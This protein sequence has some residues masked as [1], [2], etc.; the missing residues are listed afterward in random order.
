MTMTNRPPADPP[1][2]DLVVRRVYDAPR[3]LVWQAWTDPHH[4]AQWWGPRM[5]TNPLCEVDLRPGGTLLIHMRAPDGTV[6]PMRGV[7]EEVVPPE[8]LVFRDSALE[9][10]HGQPQL[11]SLTTVLFAERGRQTEVTVRAHV[12]TA[13]AAALGAL[14]G[15]EQG[16]NESLDKLGEYLPAMQA[17]PGI[18]ITRTFDAPRELVFQ[19]WTE[20]ARFAQWFGAPN[21]TIP[22]DT[23]SMDLRP[24]GAWR[25][26]MYAGPERHA[27]H[28]QGTYLEVEPPE[29]LVF[30]I[31]DQPADDME[32]VTVTLTDLGG[33]TEM[34]FQ[35]AGGHLAPEEYA[36]AAHGWGVFFDQM[37]LQLAETHAR[38]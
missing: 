38:S 33:R 1:A 15:M 9:D 32:V 8:R 19:A 37:A 11:E 25:A 2:P 36:R 34:V 3:A 10:E 14:A 17:D 30:T 5:F 21:A 26:T 4:L 29:R 16:W 35:Q 27:I 24:G 12:I 22:L 18:R 31:T 13:T 20:P 28:W 6:F 23:V 7:F